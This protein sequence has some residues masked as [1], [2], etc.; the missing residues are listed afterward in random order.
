MLKLR[1]LLIILC[2]ICF[3]LLTAQTVSRLE[4]LHDIDLGQHYKYMDY[5]T[6]YNDSLLHFYKMVCDD[7]TFNVMHWTCNP[8]GVLTTPISI[9]AY[10]SHMQNMDDNYPV[11]WSKSCG[12]VY[13]QFIAQNNF[14]LLIID[15]ASS[16]Q[17]K[18]I[19][20]YQN[21]YFTLF[22]NN[23]IYFEKVDYNNYEVDRYNLQT[24]IIDSVFTWSYDHHPM[25]LNI[26]NKYLLIYGMYGPNPQTAVMIDSLQNIHPCNLTG[27]NTLGQMKLHS[28]EIA[29]D[30]YL[31]GND[32][33][34]EPLPGYS[35]G[36]LAVNNYNVDF[37]GLY[38]TNF[39]MPNPVTSHQFNSVIPY[40]DGRFSCIDEDA[41]SSLNSFRNYQLIGTGFTEDTDFPNLSAYNPPNKLVKYDSR[42]ALALSGAYVV[43]RRLLCIDYQNQTITDTTFY[44]ANS[45]LRDNEELTPAY[46]YFY[47]IFSSNHGTLDHWHLQIGKI[48]DV[49]ENVDLT[50]TPEV[51]SHSAYPNPFKDN[52]TIKI[53]LNKPKTVQAA[54]YNLKGQLVKDISVNAKASL[55]HDLLWDGTTANNT[56]ASAGLYF[57]K[58]RT[59]SGKTITGKLLLQK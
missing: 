19:D 12:K 48:V 18:I 57:Y 55:N 15:E 13:V 35:F 32:D 21:R 42:Y 53:T 52:T 43:N 58:A 23:Y 6:S 11:Q 50:Q 22:T 17:H 8:S 27:G 34:L 33:A 1:F 7:S 25:F 44:V 56:K 30:V 24:D 49:V 40:G 5:Q 41:I 38:Y 46:N 28:G 9:Y 51:M 26:G 4:R 54:I 2:P 20:E 37:H 16:V 45:N 36:Y 39:E 59:S 14:H 29:D 31:A 3:S 10:N 47:Y